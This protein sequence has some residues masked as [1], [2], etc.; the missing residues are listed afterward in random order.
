MVVVIRRSRVSGLLAAATASAC[1]RWWLWL[2]RSHAVAAS[3]RAASAAEKILGH[4]DGA[5]GGV[6]FHGNGECLSG[7][8]ARGLAHLCARAEQE[9]SPHRRDAGTPGVLV[10]GDVHLGTP[11]ASQ[12]FDDGIGDN[13]TGGVATSGLQLGRELHDRSV[14]HVPPDGRGVPRLRTQTRRSRSVSAES[15][16][17]LPRCGSRTSMP[18]RGSPAATPGARSLP[19][20]RVPFLSGSTSTHSP[21]SCGPGTCRAPGRDYDPARS[22]C[23]PPRARCFRSPRL[24]DA[25]RCTAD[26]PRRLQPDACQEG[27]R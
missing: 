4:L 25:L 22:W 6:E 3:G 15:R 17:S 18:S 10:H 14:R 19:R 12:R 20:M 7:G 23:G 5:W 24:G 8:D 2:S 21:T 13:E 11:P 16:S 26:E 27:P 9:P 1:C